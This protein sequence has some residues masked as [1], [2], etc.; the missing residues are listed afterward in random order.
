[1]RFVALFALF[2]LAPVSGRA[3]EKSVTYEKDIEPIFAK[4]CI[5]CHSGEVTKGRLDLASY[6]ALVKGGKRGA[7]VTPGNSESSLLY[8]AISRTGK[9]AMPPKGEEP[10]TDAEIALVKLWIDQGAK[11][12]TGKR[13]RPKVTVGLPPANVQPVRALAVCPDKSAIAVGRG[14]QIHIYDPNSGAHMRSLIDPDLKVNGDQEVH[15]AHIA[16]VDSLAYSP[17][18]KFLVSGSFQEIAIWAMPSG[19]FVKRI[20]GFAHAVVAL[21]FAPDG[22]IFAT[23]GGA[24]TDAGE[25][26]VFEVDSWKEIT[27][28]KNGHSDT[29]YGICFGPEG[30]MLASASADKFIKVWEIPSGK[31]VK[32]FE[33]HT[34]HVLDIGWMADGKLLASAG[35]DNTVKIWDFEKGEQ[36]R[37]IN[38]HGKQVTRLT[39]IGKKNEILTCGGDGTVKKFNATNGGNIGNFGGATDFVYA[40][41]ASPDGQIIAAGGQD[42]VVRVYNGANLQL[43]KTLVPP[44]TK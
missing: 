41:G 42:G 3:Q 2:A 34:H 40:I 18:G 35:A 39:F 29:V 7:T 38:A 37:T 43:M 23:A 4:R 30:K 1:M 20:G 13:E 21:A 22:K 36:V 17:D 26:K 15:A 8:Q 14:N 6:E 10:A 31:L 32:S 16:L 27:D 33:G 5:A 11:A 12:P 28:I 24:P 25:I 44:Q 9:P 19:E